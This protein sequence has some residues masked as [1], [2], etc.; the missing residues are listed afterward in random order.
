MYLYGCICG[1]LSSL[2]YFLILYCYWPEYIQYFS[3]YEKM[4]SKTATIPMIRLAW[5]TYWTYSPLYMPCMLTG[6]I[7]VCSFMVQYHSVLTAHCHHYTLW[8]YIHILMFLFEMVVIYQHCLCD[9]L[10]NLIYLCQESV[11]YDTSI[12]GLSS[13][14]IYWTHLSVL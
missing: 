11:L 14:S 5:S 7:N 9:L 12:W 2:Y 10:V 3:V 8:N 1:F 13:D 6:W 4:Q